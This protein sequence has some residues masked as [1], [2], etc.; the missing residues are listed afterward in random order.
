MTTDQIKACLFIYDETLAN[1][2]ENRIK[3]RALGLDEGVLRM[4]E[5]HHSSV[6]WADTLREELKGRDELDAVAN[7][8]YLNMF[9]DPTSS[10]IV[11]L[12]DHHRDWEKEMIYRQA[13]AVVGYYRTKNEPLA[14]WEIDLL[15]SGKDEK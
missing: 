13:E 9:S 6:E 1:E 10:R 11:P 4:Y 15:N 7:L 12:K 5:M 3:L 2:R 14:Q 8:I